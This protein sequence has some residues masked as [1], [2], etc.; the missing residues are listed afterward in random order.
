MSGLVRFQ[1]CGSRYA[2]VGRDYLAC[3]AARGSGTCSNRQSI[4]R[5]ALEGLIIDGL[6]QRLM[7]PEFV[8]EFI[9]A[10][11]KEIN[12]QR[13]EGDALRD[14]KTR[15][16][17]NVK[18][19]LDGLIDAI[20]DGLRA[21]GLQQRLDEL[22]TRRVEIEQ[23]LAAEPT[24]PVR[25]HPNLALVYRSQV[26]RLQHSLN[27]PDIRD[28]ALQILRG[29]IEHVSIGP[30]EHGLEIEIVGKIAKMVELGIGNKA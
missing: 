2:A 27:Q 10:F 28:E 9:R 15:E 23:S 6:R 14:V 5:A 11:H 18:R 1:E 12:L 4:R 29:L 24:S 13:R 21:P 26:E 25:L 16:L 8:E 3:S 17:V 22:E 7:A 20:A 30:A 19:K